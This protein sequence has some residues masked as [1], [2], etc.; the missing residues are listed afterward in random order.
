[1][2]DCEQWATVETLAMLLYVDK[3]RRAGFEFFGLDPA[4]EH[5][6]N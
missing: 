2:I 3:V 6:R 4:A 5:E 1:M